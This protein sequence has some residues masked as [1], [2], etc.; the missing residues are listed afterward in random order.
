[1]RASSRS[2]NGLEAASRVTYRVVHRVALKPKQSSKE[3]SRVGGTAVII[4]I[5]EKP[6]DNKMEISNTRVRKSTFGKNGNNS[7][8]I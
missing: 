4:C 6:R 7:P 1:M 8:K 5:S 2:F 3:K